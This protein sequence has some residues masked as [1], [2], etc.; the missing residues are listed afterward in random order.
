MK[1][2][3]TQRDSSILIGDIL[4]SLDHA[5][6]MGGVCVELGSLV[7]KVQGWV[8]VKEGYWLQMSDWSYCPGMIS[9]FWI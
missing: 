1:L 6:T 9:I 5:L 8:G 7:V 4:V 3:D 2:N